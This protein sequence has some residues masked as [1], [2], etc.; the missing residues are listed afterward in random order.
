MSFVEEREKV[1]EIQSNFYPLVGR[2]LLKGSEM[3]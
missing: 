2:V 3:T 1:K